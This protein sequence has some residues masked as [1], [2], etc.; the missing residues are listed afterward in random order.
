MKAT[1]QS[2]HFTRTTENPQN[3]QAYIPNNLNY[4]KYNQNTNN[5]LV[6]QY[7]D[8]QNKHMKIILTPIQLPYHHQKY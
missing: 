3:S 2:G 5:P 7:I 6:K 8:L 4:F 1:N